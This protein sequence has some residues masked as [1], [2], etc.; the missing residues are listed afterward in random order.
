MSLKQ[1]EHVYSIS[2]CIL[3]YILKM[4]RQEKVFSVTNAFVGKVLVNW[5]GCIAIRAATSLPTYPRGTGSIGPLVATTD[6][7]PGI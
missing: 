7:V 5:T 2:E 1:S 3:C 6:L 4:N